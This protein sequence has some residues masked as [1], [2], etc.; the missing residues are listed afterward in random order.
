MANDGIWSL[1][2]AYD[3]TYAEGPGGEH[4]MTILGEGKSPRKE[5]FLKIA[6]T[7]SIA[8]K[9]AM[10]IYHQVKEAV[11]NWDKIARE[12]GV[13]KKTQVLIKQSLVS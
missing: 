12:C 6:K 2:P 5:H 8:Q 11:G 1:A 3:L 7:A 10:M 9:E 13:S 4:S